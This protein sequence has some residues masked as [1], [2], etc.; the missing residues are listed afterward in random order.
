[1]KKGSGRAQKKM[2]DDFNRFIGC[3]ESSGL[4]FKKLHCGIIP[5][6]EMIKN[7]R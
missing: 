3:E 1:M 4:I 2:R 7:K 6:R 5:N